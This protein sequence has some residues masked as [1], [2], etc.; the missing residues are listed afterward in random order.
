MA[1]KQDLLAYLKQRDLNAE[2][3]YLENERARSSLGMLR[4][5]ETSSSG[6]LPPFLAACSGEAGRERKGYL[7]KLKS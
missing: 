4:Q 5:S 6:K 3:R 2:K 7:G 1:R